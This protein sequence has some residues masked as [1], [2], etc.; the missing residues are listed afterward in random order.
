MRT[1]AVA[2]ALALALVAAAGTSWAQSSLTKVKLK[3]GQTLEGTVLE[4]LPGGGLKLILVQGGTREVRGDEIAA[5]ER[6]GVK[7]EE[8]ARPAPA[9]PAPPSPP[10]PETT[11]PAEAAPPPVEAQVEGRARG[12]A[13]E[14]CEARVDCAEGLRCFDHVCRSAEVATEAA[15][16]SSHVEDEPAPSRR[17]ESLDGWYGG[18]MAGGAVAPAFPGGAGVGGATAFAGIRAGIVDFRLGIGG[19]GAAFPYGSMGV[20]VI[21]PEVFLF[22]AGPY[23]FGVSFGPAA[24]YMQDYYGEG[25]IGGGLASATPVALRFEAGEAMI[26]PSLSAGAIFGVRESVEGIFARPF[27]LLALAVYSK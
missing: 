3:S 17:S 14:S 18:G 23:G 15:A 27:G 8:P 11:G 20:A 4:E 19:F 10:P 1:R 25:V 6:P 13:G 21:R 12:E 2:I 7:S 5:V 22:V 16:A 26:E 9:P 24:G